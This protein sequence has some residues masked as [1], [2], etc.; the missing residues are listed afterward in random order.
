MQVTSKVSIGLLL[1]PLALSSLTR[2]NMTVELTVNNTLQRIMPTD[3]DVCYNF[4]EESEPTFCKDYQFKAAGRIA[5]E[6]A[7]YV[8]TYVDCGGPEVGPT[9]DRDIGYKDTLCDN[10][11]D[12][13]YYSYKHVRG[14]ALRDGIAGVNF[15][16][17]NKQWDTPINKCQ[18]FILGNTTETSVRIF[19]PGTVDHTVK[20]FGDNECKDMYSI[21]NLDSSRD[22]FYTIDYAG[23]DY[24][25]SFKIE[26]K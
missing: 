17:S 18:E 20:I 5:Q 1:A 8:Y 21:I 6:D 22:E 3:Y 16:P 10:V 24:A 2:S 14:G 13:W 19:T 15:D 7:I 26:E 11:G 12:V 25:F 23:H 9:L 4:Y